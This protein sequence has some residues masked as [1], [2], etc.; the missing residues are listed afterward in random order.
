[1][2]PKKVIL[3]VIA[4]DVVLSVLAYT[5]RTNGYRV[6]CAGTPAVAV[7]L[8]SDNP[9]DLVLAEFCLPEMDGNLLIEQLKL[10]A[11][12]IPMILLGDL[13]KFEGV[14][15]ADL[16]LE[17]STISSLEMLERIK[18]LSTRKRGPRKGSTRILFEPVPEP[19]MA[20]V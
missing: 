19:V 2:R 11:R 15:A 9:V 12:H 1:M 20:G 16:F 5:L 18:V 10:T 17:S 8:F 13:K 14:Y 3:C 6:L 4:D 7:E